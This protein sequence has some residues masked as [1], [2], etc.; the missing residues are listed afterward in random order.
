M[1]TLTQ[2]VSTRTNIRPRS[3]GWV[4]VVG[5]LAALLA[6]LTVNVTNDALLPQDQAVMDWVSG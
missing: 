3:L 1:V 4:G 5:L 2:Q 6:W